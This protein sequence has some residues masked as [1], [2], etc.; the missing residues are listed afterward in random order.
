MYFAMFKKDTGLVEHVGQCTE[1]SF[2]SQARD[3][4]FGVIELK[5]FPKPRKKYRVTDA[6]E[7]EEVVE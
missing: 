7:L 5:T 2:S 3:E 1:D 6:N 4:T